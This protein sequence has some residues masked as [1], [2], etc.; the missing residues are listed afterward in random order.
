MHSSWLDAMA[1]ARAAVP[2]HELLV[3]DAHLWR[4]VG[5][6]PMPFA[7]T[8]SFSMFGRLLQYGQAMVMSL[9]MPSHAS[10][11]RLL[12]YAHRLRMDAMDG[13]IRAN[14]LQPAKMIERSDIVVLTRPASRHAALARIAD[15]H[16]VTLRLGQPCPPPGKRLRTVLVDGNASDLLALFGLIEQACRPFL[17]VVDGT[18]AGVGEQAGYVQA[19]LQE[20]F[21]D[22]PHVSVI[23]AGDT[24]V[25]EKMVARPSRAH[26]W[27]WR[28]GD[29]LPSG[30]TTGKATP[31]VT[32]ARLED[33]TANT[34]LGAAADALRTL[35]ATAVPET[36]AVRQKTVAPL[37]KVFTALRTLALPLDW[38]EKELLAA[39]RGG[40]FP[41]MTLK[42]WME[43]ARRAE[44]KYAQ[45]GNAVTAAV[46]ALEA[47][48]G[49][50]S[51]ATCGKAQAVLARVTA[52]ATERR[53]LTLL[54]G[55]Q[56]E[57]QAVGNWLNKMLD[58]EDHPDI[59]ILPMDGVRSLA[60]VP[61]HGGE[62]LVLGALW[63][64]RL[65]WLMLPANQ[66]LFP[67]YPFESDLLR[68]SLARW[69]DQWGRA[70][71][72]D[73]DK[74]RLW[75]LDWPCQGRCLDESTESYEGN[76]VGEV[77]L[78]HT[79][80]YRRP[81]KI[82]AISM[83]DRYD[84]WIDVLMADLDRSLDGEDGEHSVIDACDVAWLHL[85]QASQPVAWPVNKTVIVLEKDDIKPHL[86]RDLAP[87]DRIVLLRYSDERVATQ[88]ALF[89]MF[90]SESEGMEEIAR[91]ATKWQVLVDEVFTRLKTVSAVRTLLERADVNVTSQTISTW[92]R[93]ERIGPENPKVIE[94]F[95]AACERK[96]PAKHASKVFN[97]IEAIRNQHRRIGRDLN[98]ALLAHANGADQVS[99]GSLRLD[100]DAFSA[101][102][103]V[104]EI[105]HVTLPEM[106]KAPAA[107]TL[108]EV[109]ARHLAR[110]PERLVLT[111]SASRSLKQCAYKD[112]ERFEVCLEMMATKLWPLYHGGKERMHDLIADFEARSIG[113]AGG[114]AATTQGR[115]NDYNRTYIGRHFKLGTAWDPT[116]TMRIHFHWDEQDRQIVIHH[117][118]EHLKTTLG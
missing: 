105:E 40:R 90:C 3:S 115:S 95:A 55:S 96:A 59:R 61:A 20:Y 117:A 35:S 28:S 97:A 81:L 49:A 68:R 88:V 80:A 74:L 79:G 12:S 108:T 86:P 53:A 69:W 100:P 13:A 33:E 19:L 38:L 56:F 44:C 25:M 66:V 75:R 76:P 34:L 107:P 8:S 7:E 82:V 109:A 51:D 4:Q 72:R 47:A 87:G 83:V 103:E 31:Y 73:G 110:Y 63:P 67:A 10:F 24:Q 93:G 15:L 104:C 102:V 50:M 98:A 92:R 45:T 112:V 26:L 42:R 84:D 6:A 106:E 23:S 101:M 18:A 17:F 27:R 57:A 62:V 30:T 113:F 32:V 91:F 114:T 21:P 99:I 65:P 71:R 94:V 5:L 111:S 58:L 39:T 43:T 1:S 29:N 41:I 85:R 37:Y 11:A 9:P 2:A 70:S 64:N 77:T 54:V 48:Y 36:P 46:K 78:P 60:K 116:L 22:I 16:T 14:W 89:Q 52:A 118:G